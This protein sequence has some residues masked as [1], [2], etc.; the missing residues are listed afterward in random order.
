[1]HTETN[2]T[3]AIE[4]ISKPA[5]G[6]GYGVYGEGGFMG[7]RDMPIAVLTPAGGYGLYGDATG[8]AATGTR[9]GVYGSAHGS[10]V[11]YGI[12]GTAYAGTANWAGF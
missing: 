9:V 11:N 5:D 1:M 8:T 3:R 4:G 2:D 10:G 12:Y 7:V 6:W